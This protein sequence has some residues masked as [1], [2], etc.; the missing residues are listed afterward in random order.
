[1]TKEDLIAELE[2]L[3]AGQ[4]VEFRVVMKKIAQTHPYPV[5]A[6]FD[7]IVFSNPARVELLEK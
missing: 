1:M 4:Q 2:K 5:R 6:E 7:R 3:P